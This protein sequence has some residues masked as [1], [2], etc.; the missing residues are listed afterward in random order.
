MADDLERGGGVILGFLRCLVLRHQ[1]DRHRV[2]KIGND[3]YYGY[4]QHCNAKI[5]RIR[6][7][8]WVRT[9]EWPD[10]APE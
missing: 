8:S 6:R 3:S 1:P 7:D 10:S 5:R 4:C 9:R 2:K